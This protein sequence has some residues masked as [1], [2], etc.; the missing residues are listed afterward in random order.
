MDKNKILKCKLK[1]I[2]NVNI[3]LFKK[4]NVYSINKK[5]LAKKVITLYNM[6]EKIKNNR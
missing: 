6:N 4:L 1:R 3:K 2:H 5:M